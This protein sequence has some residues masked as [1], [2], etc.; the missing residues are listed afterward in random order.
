MATQR[1][2]CCIDYLRI[3]AMKNGESNNTLSY[4]YL[5]K[6]TFDL[7]EIQKRLEVDLTKRA[8]DNSPTSHEV[9]SYYRHLNFFDNENFYSAEGYL[10]F[11]G[12]YI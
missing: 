8:G 5:K 10:Y 3:N 11:I 9:K 4:L 2:S 12:S 7:T 1:L 6:S